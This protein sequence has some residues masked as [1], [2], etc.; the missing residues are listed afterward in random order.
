MSEH[1]AVKDADKFHFPHQ[2][3]DMR[4]ISFPEGLILDIGGG[5]EGIIGLLGGWRVISIDLSKEELQETHNDALKI[6]MDAK[7]LKFLN[8]SFKTAASFFSLMFIPAELHPVVFK[9]IARVLEPGGKFL[10]WDMTFEKAKVGGRPMMTFPLTVVMPG[11]KTIETGYGC[12]THEQ[13]PK[14]FVAMAAKVGLR[15]VRQSRE[16]DTFFLELVK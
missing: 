9:E 2:T 3:V 12:W 10:I 16:G 15:E 5:G 11:G 8:N 1:K 6:V 14:D 7:D 4:A 13:D